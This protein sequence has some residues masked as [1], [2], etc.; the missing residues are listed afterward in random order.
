MTEEIAAL[1]YINQVAKF[2]LKKREDIDEIV[3]I[4]FKEV[5]DDASVNCG[6][7]KSHKSPFQLLTKEDVRNNIHAGMINLKYA[8]HPNLVFDRTSGSAGDTVPFAYL[9]GYHRYARMVFSF[10]I[11][12]DWKWGEKYCVFSTLHCSRDRC[13]TENLPAFVHRV[14]VATSD[15]IFVD[16]EALEQASAIL[17]DN[18]D[19]IVH[20]DPFYLSAVASY[21]DVKD[22]RLSFKGISSTYELLTP[23]VKRYLERIFQCKVFDSY[24]CSEFGPVAFACQHD[25]KHIFEDSV[26]VEIVDQGRYLDHEAGEIV[27]T[28]L[29]NPAMPLIRY[30]TGDIGKLVTGPCGCKRTTKM[31][32]IYGR[33]SQC[34]SFKGVLYSERDI[35]R[36]MDIPGVL[37][38]QL[39]QSGGSLVFNILLGNGYADNARQNKIEREIKN[40]FGELGVGHISV[41]FV[42]H[43]SPENSGKFKTVISSLGSVHE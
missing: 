8:D 32:E 3:G 16:K 19:S 5:L 29:D 20:G 26:F 12:T 30:R 11:N 42:N 10:L 37:V 9:Q 27:V 39:T 23:Y 2:S 43:I 22:I 41:N 36:L 6:F 38:Y 17:I 13:S 7:Y 15:N 31:I 35:A 24:G 25:G 33:D 21:L 1:A 28:S 34:V 40:K 4:K 14:K 18:Q